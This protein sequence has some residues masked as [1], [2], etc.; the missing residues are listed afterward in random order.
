MLRS[1]MG[2]VLEETA[3]VRSVGAGHSLDT[4]LR[5]W[6]RGR[7]RS[8]RALAL[9]LEPCVLLGSSGVQRC[10]LESVWGTAPGE[11]PSPGCDWHPVSVNTRLPISW[12][13]F[14]LSFEFKLSEKMAERD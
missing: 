6:C 2:A 12:S 1:L 14:N 13:L 4:D 5:S 3:Q 10:E 9:D 11:L 7:W 8:H